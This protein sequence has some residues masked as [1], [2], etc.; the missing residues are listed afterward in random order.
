MG[1]V[2]SLDF[3]R[4]DSGGYEMNQVVI[5]STEHIVDLSEDATRIERERCLKI[6][7][8]AV[9]NSWRFAG[10]FLGDDR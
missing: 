9:V 7:D 5:T 2:G 1:G 8:E 4:Q 6:C 10:L 3:E